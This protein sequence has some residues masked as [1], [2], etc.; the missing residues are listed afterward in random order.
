[1]AHKLWYLFGNYF[2]SDKFNLLSKLIGGPGSSVGIVTAYGLDCPGIES[3]W[4]ARISA[5]VETCREAHTASCKMGSESF[6]AVRCGRGVT[7][8]PLP[9]LVPRSK[10]E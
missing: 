7:L 3:R 6:P 4:G 10:I 1:L 8:T 5:P 9:L 2:H